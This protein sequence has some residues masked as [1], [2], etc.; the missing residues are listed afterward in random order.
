M[1]SERGIPTIDPTTNMILCAFF[2]K[3]VTILDYIVA[4]D[5]DQTHDI[6]NEEVA[7]HHIF[8]RI[9]IDCLS[10]KFKH[11]EYQ[12]NILSLFK[13]IIPISTILDGAVG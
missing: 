10:E 1:K 3:D 4:I 13:G 6:F 9:G 7:S 5:P 2:D 11:S 12:R 8:G